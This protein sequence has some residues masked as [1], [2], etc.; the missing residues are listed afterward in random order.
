MQGLFKSHGPCQF[1][2]GESEPS[3]NPHSYNEFANVVYIDQPIGTGFS[4]G[5]GCC[6]STETAAVYVWEFL[7][8]FHATFPSFIGREFGIFAQVSRSSFPFKGSP[9]AFRERKHAQ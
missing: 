2:N 6:N 8:V 5:S 3:L 1:Y 9:L 4:Y 7:Q